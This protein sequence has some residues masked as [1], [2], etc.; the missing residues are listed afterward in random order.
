MMNKKGYGPAVGWLMGIISLFTLG[1]LY[2]VFSQVF[3]GYL[4]PAL[5]DLYNQTITNTTLL[6]EIQADNAK[7]DAFWNVVPYVLFFAVIIYMFYNAII[8]GK[9]ENGLQ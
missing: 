9:E 2:V 7:Y 8:K 5:N 6:A 1:L 3:V 4:D